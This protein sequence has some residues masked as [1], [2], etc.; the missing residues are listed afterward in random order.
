VE[1]ENI[2]AGTS[3]TRSERTILKSC[4]YVVYSTLWAAI[5]NREEKR[6]EVG[7]RITQASTFSVEVDILC[8]YEIQG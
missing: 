4:M 2:G 3:G 8:F 5:S 6:P 7:Q 1:N